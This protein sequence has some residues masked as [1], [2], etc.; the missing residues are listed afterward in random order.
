M[1]GM[2]PMRLSSLRSGVS[3][4]VVLTLPAIVRSF[5]GVDARCSFSIC[6]NVWTGACVLKS[7]TSEAA[8]CLAA[9]KKFT[10]LRGAFWLDIGCCCCWVAGTGT[11]GMLCPPST[12][13]PA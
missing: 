9:A 2:A 11:M 3:L 8:G 1:I 4:P 12:V 6:S 13:K 5:C 7:G 10:T